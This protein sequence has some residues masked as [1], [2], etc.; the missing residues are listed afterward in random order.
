MKV[1]IKTHKSLKDG[2]VLVE[3]G[4]IDETDLLSTNIS[5]KCG[6]VLEVNIPKL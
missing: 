6:E 2:W 4:S 5:D 3:V 1:G